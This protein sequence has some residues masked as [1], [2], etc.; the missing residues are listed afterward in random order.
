MNTLS[1]TEEIIEN[2]KR[3]D[4]VFDT[5]YKKFGL[6]SI[7]LNTNIY[8]SI[9]SNIIGQ[10]LSDKVKKVIYERF[11]NLV[12]EIKPTNILNTSTE[13]IRA[14]GISYSKIKYIKELSQ[15]VHNNELNFDDLEKYND[16][17]LIAEFRKI[18]GVGEWTAEMLAIFSLGRENI[19]SKKDAALRNGIKKAKNYQTLSE[20]RFNNLRKKYSPYCSY[21][22]LYFYAL[23]DE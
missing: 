10:Q 22:S 6:I 20:Q 16:E 9:I 15:K 1:T 3:K 11:I 14:C 2:L 13:D 17:D 5:L 4:A 21:A 18:N 7:N 12:K 23:N 8:E 19:F